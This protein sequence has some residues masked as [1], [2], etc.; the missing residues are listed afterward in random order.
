MRGVN[1][2]AVLSYKFTDSVMLYTQ[3]ARGFRYGDVNLP[4]PLQF[5]ATSL[6]QAGLTN[7]PPTFGGYPFVQNAGKVTSK[8]VELETKARATDALTLSLSGSFT[9]AEADGALVNLGAPSGSR[10]PYF[11]REI[12]TAGVDYEMPLTNVS[13]LRWSADYT[14]RS[15]AYTQFNE[16]SPLSDEIPS[17]VMLNASITY[18]LN[19]WEVALYGTNLTNN[20]LISTISPNT[21]APYQPGNM[22][23]I[24]RPRTIGIRL[25]MG[26]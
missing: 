2:R 13:K 19:Q 5:C 20:L 16:S 21:N 14:Y 22:T 3:A 10:V 25:H 17:S 1:P 6:E 26:F 4:V 18:V 12:I 11:P 8:G 24:G 23:Y 15:N 9:D 7:A